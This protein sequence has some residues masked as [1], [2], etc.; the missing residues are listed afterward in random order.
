MIKNLIVV[1]RKH[2]DSS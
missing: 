1:M 2:G